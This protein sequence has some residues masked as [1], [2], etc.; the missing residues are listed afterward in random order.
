MFDVTNFSLKD[1]T[2]CGLALRDMGNNASSMEETT[3]RIVHYLNT[4]LTDATGEKVC[5]LTRF[6]ITMPYHELDNDNQHHAQKLLGGVPDNAHLRCQTLLATVG[7]E[8]AWND[9]HQS[10][11]YKNLPLTPE[12]LNANPMYVQFAESFGVVMDYSVTPDPELI[13]ELEQ[14]SYNVFHVLDARNSEY[15]PDQIDFVK[16]YGIRSVFGFFGMLP[17]SQV[18]SVV[19]FTRAVVPRDIVNYLKPLAF[20][21]KLAIL[22]FD[23]VAVFSTS[24]AASNVHQSNILAQLRSEA[25]SLRQLVNVQEQV[26]VEQSERIQTVMDELRQQADQLAAINSDLENEIRENEALRQQAA[27]MAILE[28]RNRLAR[29]LHDSVTQSLYS[30][31]LFAEASQRLVHGGDVERAS[32]YLT[33]VGETAQQALKEMRLLVYELRP[34]AL[35]EGGLVSALQQRL[36]AVEGR[37]GVEAQLLVNDVVELPAAV[38]EELYRIAQEALNNILKHANA[39]SVTVRIEMDA[40]RV[41]LTIEDDGCGFDPKST[42]SGGGMGLVSIRERCEGLGASLTIKSTDGMGTILQI[43]LDCSENCSKG[44]FHFD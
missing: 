9:R 11:Y 41:Q 34:L 5:A 12:I 27:E 8:P 17:S 39:R 25:G 15:V 35:E 37:A 23:E 20:N 44:L 7:M 36:D 18:F 30:L 2:Q 13:A 4:H 1:M 32:G 26:V 16:P 6:F 21:I 29:D 24:V 28:E 43:T 19:I 14:T 31:T 38:E 42:A 40:D 22:P 3:N 10:N 33:Q